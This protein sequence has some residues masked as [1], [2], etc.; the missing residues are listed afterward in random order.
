MGARTWQTQSFIYWD[1]VGSGVNPIAPF[2]IVSLADSSEVAAALAAGVRDAV[3]GR[4]VVPTPVGTVLGATVATRRVVGVTKNACYNGEEL[5]VQSDGVAE[6]MVNAAVACDAMLHAVARA[7]RTSAQ[8]PFTSLEELLLPVDP[9]LTLTY[10]LCMADDAALTLS[11]SGSNAFFYPLG[12]AL[13][14]ATAQYD[15]IPVQ[16]QLGALVG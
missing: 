12:F 7:T 13:A 10:Q 2:Q 11:S 1:T 5:L 9:R 8:T 15:V 6:V 14:A 4:L 16:L 3:I